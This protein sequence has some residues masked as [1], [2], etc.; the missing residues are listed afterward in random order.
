MTVK[1][2]HKQL[3]NTLLYRLYLAYNTETLTVGQR[4]RNYLIKMNV[5]L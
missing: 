2:K 1:K 3:K 4:N 5:I